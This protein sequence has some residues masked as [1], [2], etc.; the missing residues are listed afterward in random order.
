MDRYG[1][2]TDFWS[3]KVMMSVTAVT[4]EKVWKASTA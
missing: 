3:P 1:Q 4:V 2:M